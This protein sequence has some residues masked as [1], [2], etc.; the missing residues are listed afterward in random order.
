MWLSGSTIHLGDSAVISAKG[1]TLT[2]PN[3]VVTGT[4]TGAGVDSAYVTTQIN[5]LI[6]GAPGTLNTLNEI[7]AALNDDDSA[8]ATLVNLIGAKDSDFVKSAADATWIQS[9]QITYTIPTFGND[10]V[11]SGAVTTLITTTVD[12]AYVS[13]RAGA[14]GGIS[15]VV[16]DTSPQLGGNLDANGNAIFVS[17]GAGNGKGG[18]TNSGDS[19]LIS[20]DVGASTGTDISV[21]ASGDLLLFGTG[22]VKIG[23]TIAQD[24]VQIGHTGGGTQV[25]I[26]GTINLGGTTIEHIDSASGGNYLE[27]TNTYGNSFT[28]GLKIT[29]GNSL[30]LDVSSQQIDGGMLITDGVLGLKASSGI[31]LNGPVFE[32][33]QTGTISANELT[34]DVSVANHLELTSGPSANFAINFTNVPTTTNRVQTYTLYVVGSNVY[35]PSSITVNGGTS[36]TLVWEGGSA[37]TAN[38][39]FNVYTFTLVSAGGSSTTVLGSMTSYS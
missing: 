30:T 14:G 26:P 3:L 34:F 9:Q 35:E 18:M 19:L 24:S 28:E 10:Y 37:P 4:S 5:A 12:S 32:S 11:D 1:Q 33:T 17:D 6:D 20:N 39:S 27:I 21:Y 38:G 7:A 25:S 22:V 15:N 36:L 29:G 16:E 31:G 2:I 8:Y 23:D 13:A